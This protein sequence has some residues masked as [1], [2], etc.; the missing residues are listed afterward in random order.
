MRAR[1]LA[2]PGGG[3]EVA[4]G[5]SAETGMSGIDKQEKMKQRIHSRETEVD[6]VW[7]VEDEL[8]FSC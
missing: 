2:K 8:F 3:G 7:L 4:E 6:S 1:G 5:K